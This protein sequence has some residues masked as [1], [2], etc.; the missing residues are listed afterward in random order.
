MRS[1]LTIIFLL[2]VLIGSNAYWFVAILDQGVT[3]AYTESSLE[4][5]QKQY[6]QTAIL[7]N[8]ELNGL[9]S[10]EALRRIGKDVYGLEPFV[11][12]GCIWAGQVC[13]R[14]END[15]VTGIDHDAL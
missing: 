9:S 15:Q 8:L 11:K 13:L 10:E 2:L 1:K 14:L 4:Q 6:K 5:A 3:Q 7:S 12:E